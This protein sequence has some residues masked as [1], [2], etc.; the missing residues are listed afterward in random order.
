MC[1]CNPKT[2]D[3][4]TWIKWEVLETVFKLPWSR[5][6]VLERMVPAGKFPTPYRLGSGRKCRIAW[7]L[8]EY[9]A[10]VFSRPLVD[11]DALATY[12][13]DAAPE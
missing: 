5:Q 3:C 12:F 8:C 6:H 9:K 1:E 2:Q 4:I 13:D 10:W 7:L 11:L